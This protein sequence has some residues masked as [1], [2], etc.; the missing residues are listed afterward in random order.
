MQEET[1]VWVVASTDFKPSQDVS[2]DTFFGYRC[3]PEIF[4]TQ[5]TIE[6]TREFV[7]AVSLQL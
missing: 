6:L 7:A 2:E 4:R 5:K 1:S 3:Q